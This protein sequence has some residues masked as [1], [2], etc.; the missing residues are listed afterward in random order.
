VRAGGIVAVLLGTGLL[1]APLTAIASGAATNAAAVVAQPVRE[2]R[3]IDTTELGVSRPSG[4]AYEPDAN[5]L[6]VAARRGGGTAAIRVTP[7]EDVLGSLTLPQTDPSTMTF[8]QRTN[9][10]GVIGGQTLF[11]VPADQLA[12]GAPQPTRGGLNAAGVGTP[13]GSVFDA[14]GG[15]VVLDTGTRTLVRIQDGDP[16]KGVSRI[17]LGI[18]GNAPL[19]GL[20]FDPADGLLYVGSPAEHLLYGVDGSGALKNAYDLSS[21]P[22]ADAQ[23]FTFAPSADT[24]DDPAIQ[25][26]YIA[27][28][29]GWSSSGGV[30]EASL[31]A[32]QAEAAVAVATATMVQRIATSAWSPASPDPSG[33]VYLP[34]S[35]RLETVDSEVEEVTGAG[36]H[37]VN[38]WQST[39]AGAVTDTGTTWTPAPNFSKEPTG[40]GFD[41]ASNTLFISDDTARRVWID[42]PGADVRFGTAD[43]VVTWI[44]AA[45]YG[46]LDTEDPEFDP[47]TGHLFFIDGVNVE[48]YDVDP[49]DGIFGNGNDTM[50]HFDMG[51]Y[52]PTDIEGLSSDPAHNTLLVGG[53]TTKKIY[54]VTK[55]GSALVQT[56]D[57]ASTPGLRYISGLAL[58]PASDN[59]GRMDYWT[60][61]RN[62]DNGPDP[63]ENDGQIFE[64]TTGSTGNVAP[65]VDSATIDQTTPKTNDTLTVT[66]AAHDDNGDPLT[67]SY[68]WRKNG[69]SLTGQ[70]N[71]TLDLSVAGN[72]DKADA[73]SVR[74]IAS[75]G[76][77]ASAPRTSSQRTIVDSLPAFNQD[78]GNQANNEGD[79]ISLSAAATDADGDPLTYEASALP[80]GLSVDTATGLISGTIAAGAASGSPYSVSVA[81]RE[82]AT[83]DATDTFTW[84]VASADNVPPVVDS[85]TIDQTTPKTNDTLTATVAAHDDNGNPLTYSY[86]WRKNG[87]SLTG[88][89]N[90]T[91]DLSVAGNG[92]KADAISVQVIASDGVAAS[93]PRTS[94]DVTI[95]DSRPAFNQDLGNRTSQEGDVIS[96][97]AAATDADGDPLTYE[98][99]GLPS[100]LSI[101]TATGLIS[102]TIA[103]GAAA[104]SP[105]SVSVAVRE[106]ATPDATDTFTWTVPAPDLPPAAPT[107]LGAVVSSLAVNLDWANNTEADLSGY[108]VYRASQPGGP[109][110]KLNTALL[111]ASQYSD[112]SAPRGTSYYQV[113]AVDVGSHESA[114]AGTSAVR[115]ILLRSVTSRAAKDATSVTISKPAGVTTGD[116]M[117]AA[118]TV[119]G[120]PTITAPG[121]WTL[122]RIDTNGS[123]MRQVVYTKFAAGSEPS[124]YTWSFSAKASS[125]GIIVAYQGIDVATP[126]DASSGQ[127][128]P[129]STAITAPALSASVPGTLLV[130]FFGT[131]GNA[132]TAPPTG[133]IEQAE[134]IQS[135]GKNKMSLE[136]ADAFLA[137]T[138]SSGTRVATAGSASANVGQLVALR[139]SP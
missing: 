11:T 90:A 35:D 110:T 42:K 82:G 41:A 118:V 36:Y 91:L 12:A 86:Q 64:F 103:A 54:E 139:P 45:A 21:L 44:D 93:A 14:A 65:V 7:T 8:D 4:I 40:L 88:Q 123:A 2:V 77:A 57:A 31:T 17:P 33:I 83:P 22:V 104:G 115:T 61:D 92:D 105:Y 51:Q 107:G 70:T 101:D 39:R 106:G 55:D 109:Y 58:A 15:L 56:I 108:N 71:P 25:D 53:R 84:T 81:V 112:R 122:A 120:A 119:R 73:I 52:G 20:A 111:T 76:V 124:S 87:V 16:A 100:G 6:V 50:T 129:A 134:I 1:V 130:G 72:G 95:V 94:G 66:V 78:L 19:R 121:G 89:T 23:G 10:L 98:A 32:P 85:V 128:N 102:G 24:T 37:D 67:Y 117:V 80:S 79:A 99:S 18:A 63:T 75:D 69:V 47:S 68:Q 43:D 3:P 127:P 49:V 30:M 131:A 96:L 125:A 116:L 74:V 48:V 59:S 38:M 28:G 126:V 113:T 133:M 97:S 114:P 137:G 46:S 5:A 132:A 62:I 13:A 27:D 34:G 135:A 9:R 136:A 29:G 138:G 26:L 60:V